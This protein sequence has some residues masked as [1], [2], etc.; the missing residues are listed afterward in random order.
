MTMQKRKR[1]IPCRWCGNHAE[2]KDRYLSPFS[3]DFGIF[4]EGMNIYYCPTENIGFAYPV[5]TADE[6]AT[7]YNT[8]YRDRVRVCSEDPHMQ[9]S[10]VKN[11]PLAR[12]QRRY[13]S[14]F[15]DLKNVETVIDMGCGHGMLLRQIRK[16]NPNARLV[17]VEL[18]S[19][20]QPFLHEIGVDVVH[21][22]ANDSVDAV[23]ESVGNNTLLISSH[24][25]HYQEDYR[26]LN[27]IIR[28][29]KKKRVTNVHLFVEVPN[30]MIHDPQYMR[31][32]VYDVPKLIFFTKEAF[33]KRLLDMTLLNASTNGW[34]IE[35]EILFRRKR[36]EE[37]QKIRKYGGRRTLFHRVKSF[38]PLR[39]R[40]LVK[41]ALS[42]GD[43]EDTTEQYFSYGGDRR[44]LRVFGKIM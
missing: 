43:V 30:D 25:L 35:N 40:M 19:D 4:K 11:T 22:S 18:D 8:I 5:P 41:A 3:E 44:A 33:E 12:S 9:Y 36:L 1:T 10:I 17:G 32:R 31:K 42:R 6:L 2:Y 21:A 27:D 16:V 28:G 24:A 26:F 13:I 20:V 15:V 23:C 29:I 7:Y 38:I 39:V 37:Y 34:L 14:R